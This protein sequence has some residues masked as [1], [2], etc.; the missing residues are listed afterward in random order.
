ML[1]RSF[2]AR[3]FVFTQ[4]SPVLANNAKHLG[5]KSNVWVEDDDSWW[6]SK[7][8]EL[9]SKD[10]RPTEVGVHRLIEYYNLDALTNKADLLKDLPPSEKTATAGMHTSFRTKATFGGSVGEDFEASAQLH[11]YQSK[12]WISAQEV[13]REKHPLARNTKPTSVVFTTPAKLYCADQFRDVAKIA[14]CPVSGMKRKP[15]AGDFKE[16]LEKDIAANKYAT[17]LYFT[18]SQLEH[19]GLAADLRP[20]AMPVQLHLTPMRG[21][22]LLYDVSSVEGG[23][24]L[25]DELQRFP[26]EEHTFL[27]SGRPIRDEQTLA[28][29]KKARNASKYWIS[30]RD[31]STRGYK[32]KE[33]AKGVAFQGG[34][35]QPANQLTVLLYNVAQLTNP[36]L[37]FEKAGTKGQL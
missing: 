9:K 20:D 15:Y 21:E 3:I 26:V 30:G 8:T 11:G 25:V 34:S 37:G 6:W 29:M 2:T 23:D 5:Y 35:K 17:G 1:R 32:I 12:F 31:L 33:G 24:K 16:A 19:F 36:D 10:E 18:L 22:T 28:E 7:V 4:S 13:R 27:I 14:Q